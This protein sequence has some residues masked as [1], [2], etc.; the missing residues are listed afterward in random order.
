M[1][2][3]DSIEQI[4]VFFVTYGTQTSKWVE[5]RIHST[6]TSQRIRFSLWL[7]SSSQWA[8]MRWFVATMAPTSNVAILSKS[9]LR[10]RKIPTALDRTFHI[11]NDEKGNLLSVSLLP[12]GS[13]TSIVIGGSLCDPNIPTLVRTGASKTSQGVSITPI[14]SFLIYY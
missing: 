10:T 7:D 3:K 6:M 1:R 13:A 9:H 2:A 11:P 4:L 12:L 5:S 14:Y 8:A